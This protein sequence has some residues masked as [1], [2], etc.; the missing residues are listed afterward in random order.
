MTFLKGTPSSEKIYGTLLCFT[1]G[2]TPLGY[3]DCLLGHFWPVNYSLQHKCLNVE[4]KTTHFILFEL[5]ILEIPSSQLFANGHCGTEQLG[6]VFLLTTTAV[7][8]SQR[9]SIQNK[10]DVCQWDR[11]CLPLIGR[12]ETRITEQEVFSPRD[13]WSRQKVNLVYK[14]W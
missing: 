9:L 10:N 8:W 6:S 2:C 7:G 14:A 3:K 1:V 12:M 11:L 4:S 13:V 5:F